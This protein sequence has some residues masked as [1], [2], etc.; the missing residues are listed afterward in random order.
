MILIPGVEVLIMA[1]FLIQGGRHLR[2]EIEARGFKNA[3]TPILA[4]SL[5]SSQPSKIENIPLI[6]DIFRMIELIKSLGVKVDWL[7]KRDLIIQSSCFQPEK[8]DQKVIRQMRSSILLWGVLAAKCDSFQ[9]PS[10]GGCLIG[11]RSVETHLNAFRELGWEIESNKGGLYYFNRGK[12]WSDG[13]DKEIVLDEFSVTATENLMIAAAVRS[14]KTIIKIAAADPSVQDLGRFLIKMGVR[15][16]GLGTNT[17]TICGRKKLKG[18]SYK[19]M[20]DPIEV[21]TF[22]SLAAATKSNLTIKNVP[23]D[24]LTF[25]LKKFREIGVDF[26]VEKNKVI[27]K[28]SHYFNPVKIQTLPYP[29][30]PTDL[31]A[32][33]SVLLTQAKGVSLVYETMYEGRFRYVQDLKKMGANISINDAHQILITGPTPLYGKEIKSYDLRAGASLIIAALIA[34]GESKID[35]IYQV[36]RGYEKIEERLQRIGAEIERISE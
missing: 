23:V 33:V 11:A 21:G 22:I 35:D 24:Y 6:E 2:G 1:F 34:H 25:P 27:V 29:G 36:D 19:I 31:Q 26:Y 4:A 13:K 14:G 8:V 7:N 3:A 16:K 28:P 10:P 17:L 5:L 30:F 32:P 18:A 20:P 9:T 12:N 15:I